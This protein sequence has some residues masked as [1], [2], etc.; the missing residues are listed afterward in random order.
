MKL[1]NLLLEIHNQCEETQKTIGQNYMK[2]SDEI[3]K[4]VKILMSL[5]SIYLTTYHE[6]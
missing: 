4:E 2:P 6:T 3:V 1:E 5:L